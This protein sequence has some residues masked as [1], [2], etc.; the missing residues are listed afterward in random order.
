MNKEQ[1]RINSFKNWPRHL[2]WPTRLAKAG[3][4]FD[5][6]RSVTVCFCCGLQ[7]H[8][9]FWTLGTNPRNVHREQRRDCSFINGNSDNEPMLPQPTNANGRRG[10]TQNSFSG[11][12]HAQTEDDDDIQ[13]PTMRETRQMAHLQARLGTFLGRWPSRHIVSPR[14]L[15]RTGFFFYGRRDRVKCFHCGIVLM[16]WEPG[17]HPL[18][19]HLRHSPN[20]RFAR[21][22][23]KEENLN[24]Q[25]Q[26]RPQANDRSRMS[27]A[28]I[29]Q[30]SG[31]GR[32]YNMIHAISCT[33]MSISQVQYALIRPVQSTAFYFGQSLFF[34]LV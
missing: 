22:L 12:L 34:V 19:E 6:R 17:D 29:L 23:Q 27:V 9:E 30:V 31:R 13:N 10:A 7:I 32:A 15:A 33:E 25:I 4:Y 11:H 14:A 2:V 21:D 16:N 5:E 26:Q 1:N 28:D 18:Q 24:V 20:C 8:A 3:F